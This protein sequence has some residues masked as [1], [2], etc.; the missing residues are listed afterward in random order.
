[1]LSKIDNDPDWDIL[2]SL[3][4]FRCIRCNAPA[5][6]IHEIEPKS[7]GRKNAMQF[8]NRVAICA[9]CHEWCHRYNTKGNREFLK[10]IRREYI[11]RHAPK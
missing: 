3:F 1:M 7:H 11:E 6:T 10:T 8:D 4:G 2:M 9:E 5:V